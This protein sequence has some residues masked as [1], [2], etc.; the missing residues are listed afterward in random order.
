[1]IHC[2]VESI[3]EGGSID[4]AGAWVKRVD[5]GARREEQALFYPT[6]FAPVDQPAANLAAGLG[7]RPCP[8]F[9]PGCSVECEQSLSVG[10]DAIK[11]PLNDKWIV[12]YLAV[13]ILVAAAGIVAPG[14]FES[15][16][17]VAIDFC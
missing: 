9:F 7:G 1:M 17:I 12:L 3:R 11:H 16:N 4:L 8:D 2:E 5:P 6:F 14:Q 15:M 10:S 13:Q